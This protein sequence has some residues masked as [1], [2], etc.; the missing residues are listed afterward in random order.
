MLMEEELLFNDSLRCYYCKR[1]RLAYLRIIR[2]LIGNVVGW[3]H[4]DDLKE[5]GR[6]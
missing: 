5:T 4:L 6:E 3:V 2:Q 1:S